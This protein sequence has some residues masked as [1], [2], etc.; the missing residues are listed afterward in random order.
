MNKKQSLIYCAF[1]LLMCTIILTPAY[2]INRDIDRQATPRIGDPFSL[3][4]SVEIKNDHEV[5]L[6]SK[7]DTVTLY[8]ENAYSLA[9]E[10]KIFIKHE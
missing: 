4:Y 2:L 10:T 1:T 6:V 5:K 8:L 3:P 9:D 7:Y